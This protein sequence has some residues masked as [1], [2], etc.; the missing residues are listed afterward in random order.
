M[1]DQPTSPPPK[2]TSLTPAAMIEQAMLEMI[3]NP[4]LMPLPPRQMMSAE[5]LDKVEPPAQS[6]DPVRS[7]ALILIFHG[8]R[9]QPGK[10]LRKL[11]NIRNYEGSLH[12]KS[13]AGILSDIVL[14]G[15]ATRSDTSFEAALQITPKGK[16][17]LKELR[18]KGTLDV[19]I[20][21]QMPV[22]TITR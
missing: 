8:V 16:E 12:Y 21:G 10:E 22:P 3:N 20:D 1:A 15:Y 11:L 17:R 14:N 6:S 19:G 9:S 2:F 18:F 4:T 7:N 5:I 13:P